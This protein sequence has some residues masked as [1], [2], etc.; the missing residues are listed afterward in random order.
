MILTERCHHILPNHTQCSNE[1]LEG[2]NFCALHEEVG[3]NNTQEK[4]QEKTQVG[5]EETKE[6]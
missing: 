1:A 2:S 3:S 6:N 5:Q 4:I